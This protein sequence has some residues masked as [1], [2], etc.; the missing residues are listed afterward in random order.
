MRDEYKDLI[1][2]RQALHTF[3]DLSG[4]EER[5]AAR[6]ESYLSR[7]APDE[8][9]TGIGGAG[10]AAIYNG[11][12]DGPRVVVRCELDALPIPET[13][14]LDYGSQNPGAAHKCGHDG[15]MT[16]VAGLAR[17]FHTQRPQKGTVIL[18]YQPAEEIGK[19]AL[20][21]VEDVK[22]KAL[23][24]DYV[25]ALHNLPGYPQGQVILREDV[26]ASA[27]KG[28]I[29]EL[30]GATSHAAEPEK[31]RSPAL[32]MAQLVEDLS[33]APQ[34]FTALHEA[35]KVTVIHA[36]LGEIAFGT[37]PGYAIVMATLR[38]HSQ[39]VMD[40]LA[41]KCEE[42]AMKV[43]E[44]FGLKISVRWDEAFPATVNDNSLVHLIDN[45]AQALGYAAC[46]E[47]HPF[48]WSEDFGHFTGRYS[49]AMFGLGT[50]ENHPAL[51]HPHYD[52]PDELII[53][54][55]KMFAEIIRRVTEVPETLLK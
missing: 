46:Y 11:A 21:V 9:V 54:G 37:S 10:L 36:R 30:T 22:F 34:L 17:F 4:D 41:G 8:I 48:P 27:S 51:H 6:I 45:T 53:P 38:S 52:F 23:A 19:G 39:E 47:P 18:L 35:A 50:G 32:A 16:I 15:H 42:L 25:F 5:T 7:Y 24:P 43:A 12:F 44:T 31:G 40:R 1:E 49:G 26:F 20:R 13:I 14:A 2:L 3:P 28:L 29:I 33:A 55:I